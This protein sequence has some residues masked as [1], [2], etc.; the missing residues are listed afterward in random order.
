MVLFISET[1]E[2]RRLARNVIP[3]D[4]DDAQIQSYQKKEFSYIATVTDKDDWAITDREFGSLQLQETN[5]VAADILMHYGDINDWQRGQAM[6]NLAYHS[7]ESIVKNIDTP[8]EEGIEPE[9]ERTDFKSWNKNPAVP[10]PDRLT[11]VQDFE[12]SF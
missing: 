6:K 9:T 4:F 3:A 7:L 12:E 5:L 11:N 2:C 10:P 1:A 8:V